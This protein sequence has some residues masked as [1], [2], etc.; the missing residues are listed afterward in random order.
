MDK[1]IIQYFTQAFAFIYVIDTSK[2]GGVKTDGVGI[3]ITL[4]F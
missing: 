3:E 1:M 2:E 4:S